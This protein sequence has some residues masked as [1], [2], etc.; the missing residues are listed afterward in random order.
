MRIWAVAFCRDR[1]EEFVAD[2]E[3]P[4][5]SGKEINEL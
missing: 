2:A 4:A 3:I 1:C 5:Y